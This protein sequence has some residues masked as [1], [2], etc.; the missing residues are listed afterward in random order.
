VAQVAGWSSAGVTY[1]DGDIFTAHSRSF[2]AVAYLWSYL[3]LEWEDGHWIHSQGPADVI[4]EQLQ[5]LRKFYGLGSDTSKVNFKDRHQGSYYI[6][7]SANRKE[8]L[9]NG[10]KGVLNTHANA[11]QFAW[12]MKEASELRGNPEDA[13]K[14][15]AIVDFYHPGSRM[16]YEL[17]Y[18]GARDCHT[19]T[20]QGRRR[21]SQC[22]FL[23]GHL[24]YAIDN[25][26]VYP[27]CDEPGA[28]PSYSFISH[29]GIAAGYLDAGEYEPEF[30]TP[31]SVPQGS[32][33]TPTVHSHRS[34]L[35]P[36]WLGSA[37]FCHSRWRSRGTIS[38][39]PSPT[40][41]VRNQVSKYDTTFPQRA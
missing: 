12:L 29:E 35:V 9:G 24:A 32:I 20:D 39:W 6:A 14:W 37:G 26:C 7:Y 30:V 38:A 31:S 41:G 11:L 3:T 15:Q 13:K 21:I 18:P 8:T 5:Q 19:S 22:T 27:G 2:P 1:P 40:Q 28:H 34:R 17:L 25:P 23:S 33:I 16:L 10:P 4:Y 36:W